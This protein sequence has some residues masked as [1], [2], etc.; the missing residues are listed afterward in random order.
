MNYLSQ[1]DPRSCI[2]QR[3]L[4][5]D[6]VVVATI[7]G[8]GRLCSTDSVMVVQKE[9]LFAMSRVINQKDWWMVVLD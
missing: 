9:N 5:I 8:V 7:A 2:D 4:E 1:E 3:R 6:S